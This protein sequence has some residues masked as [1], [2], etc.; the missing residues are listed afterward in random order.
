MINPA[1]TGRSGKIPLN[2]GAKISA[3]QKTKEG[4]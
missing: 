3:A 4:K 2:D 1:L